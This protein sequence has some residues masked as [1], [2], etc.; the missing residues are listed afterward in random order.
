[1]SNGVTFLLRSAIDA[2][3]YLANNKSPIILGQKRWINYERTSKI[4]FNKI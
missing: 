4:L 2:E 3:K 1:M